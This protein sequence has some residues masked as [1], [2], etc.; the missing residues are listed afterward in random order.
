MNNYH[1]HDI[2]VEGHSTGN[3]CLLPAEE[4]KRTIIF[5]NF[6]FSKEGLILQP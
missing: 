6:E 2:K 3:Y 4:D 1:K 5:D